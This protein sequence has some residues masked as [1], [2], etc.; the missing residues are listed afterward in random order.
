MKTKIYYI[1]ASLLA[2]QLSTAQVLFTE[3]FNNLALGEVS[4]DPTGT[5]PGKGGWYVEKKFDTQEPNVMIT[6]ETG[7]GNVLTIG[8]RKRN[9]GLG[10]SAHI[11]QKNINILWNNRTVGNNIFKLEYDIYLMGNNQYMID[12]YVGLI[13]GTTGKGLLQIIM[14]NYINGI[15]S[16]AKGNLSAS[17]YDIASTPNFKNI[18]LGKNNTPE[19]DNFPYN[20]WLSVELFIDYKYEAGSVIGG[21]I[22]VY[23]PA[24]NILKIADFTHNETIDLLR[25]R[26][27]GRGDFPLAV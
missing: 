15:P 14:S 1:I 17:Y 20:S 21:K 3:N 27:G 19:Y 18:Y 25:V 26:A 7:R 23:I 2:V 16:T 8:N 13:N 6:P 5:T 9:N 12:S 24:L 22:Y 4:T 10:T 11:T